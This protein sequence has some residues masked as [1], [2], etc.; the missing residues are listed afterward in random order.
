MALLIK[1]NGDPTDRR[2]I[3]LSTDPSAHWSG[4]VQDYYA[5]ALTKS[6]VLPE[7]NKAFTKNSAVEETTL[8]HACA[9]E[10]SLQFGTLLAEVCD[11]VEKMYNMIGGQ[12]QLH[13]NYQAAGTHFGY[14]EWIAEDQKES[15]VFI[16]S[17][18][19]QLLLRQTY[20]L[21]Q[22]LRHS[23]Q[24]DGLYRHGAQAHHHENEHQNYPPHPNQ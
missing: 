14:G 16:R 18:E 1:P 13:L 9:I 6:G 21:R 4:R 5:N 10:D 12:V 22:T 24:H 20:G 15:T 7:E 11:D 2:P 17:P 23:N 3:S 19:C 8:E